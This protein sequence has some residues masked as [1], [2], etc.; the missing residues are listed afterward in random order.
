MRAG[1][2]RPGRVHRLDDVGLRGLLAML[3]D[4]ERVQLYIDRQLSGLR[5]HDERW[6]SGLE[7]ALAALLAH[8]TSKTEAAASLHMSRPAFYD[9]IAKIEKLLEVDL[10]DRGHPRV[11][12]GRLDRRRDG[13]SS[14]D[15]DLPS[16]ERLH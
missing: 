8:P 12:P 15:V 10:E 14:E 1:D 7:A 11:A 2:L 6:S 16:L 13:A 4:D 3:A 9:R 5:E